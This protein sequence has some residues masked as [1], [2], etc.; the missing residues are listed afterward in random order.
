MN[1]KL[2]IIC[3]AFRIPATYQRWRLLSQINSDMEVLLIAPKYFEDR[4]WPELRIFETE[5]VNE[6]CFRVLPIN[7]RRTRFTKNGFLS[8]EFIQILKKEK[9]DLLYMIGFEVDNIVLALAGTKWYWGNKCK[10]VAFTMRGLPFPL[11]NKHYN[12]RW[13]ICKR[14]FS[15][16]CCHYPEAINILQLQG[17]FKKPIYLQT[18]VGVDV[19]VHFFSQE[20]RH[21]SRAKYA[22]SN[23]E[24]VFGMACRI[25]DSKGVFEVLE[26][27]P[28][29]KKYKL[30]VLGDGI[31]INTFKEKIVQKGLE[32]KVILA[33]F[34]EMGEGVAEALCA[35]DAFIHF[36]KSTPTWIDTFPLAVVQAMA[37]GLPVI[38]SDSGAVPYQIGNPDMIV[39]GRNTKEL[40]NKIVSILENPELMETERKRVLSR[41]ENTFEIKHLTKCLNE[42][43]LDI[44]AEKWNP[45]HQD[46]ANFIFQN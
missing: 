36:P 10:P 16:I 37:V 40:S 4:T 5:P 35:M 20:R 23:E 43:F 46:Q 8:W 22:I 30:L 38:G 42:V 17:G 21:R 13:T 45:E 2:V 25:E 11:E 34:V 18:Q 19:K 7:M 28:L 12:L 41:V 44:L 27:L 26:A 1:L 14:F 15:A 32:D 6:Q 24:F 31:H 9:P 39:K 3:E 29:D 33:G